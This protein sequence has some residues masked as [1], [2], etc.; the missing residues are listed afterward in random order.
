M[1]RLRPWAMEDAR[2]A[3]EGVRLIINASPLGMEG[4]A[5]MPKA[6]LDAVAQL[7]AGAVV[8]DMVYRPSE[9]ALLS[10]A[11]AVGVEAVG[12]LPMLVGQARAAFELFY[13]SP[14]PADTGALPEALLASLHD[15]GLGSS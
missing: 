3:L 8:F 2:Q 4:S 10:A 15:A 13:G 7:G 14:A 12:G 9:T 6:V 11:R 1:G 5:S